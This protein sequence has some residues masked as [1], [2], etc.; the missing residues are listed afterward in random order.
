MRITIELLRK[1]KACPDQ[2]EIFERE[3][4]EGVDVNE[5][6]CRRADALRLC[7]SWLHRFLPH[8]AFHDYYQQAA[9]TTPKAHPSVDEW[10]RQLGLSNAIAFVD[11]VKRFEEKTDAPIQI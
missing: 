6:N 8:L 11:A 4:P 7:V 1:M 3:W 9:R 5:A 2:I 10:L